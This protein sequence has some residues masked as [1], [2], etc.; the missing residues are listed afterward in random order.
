MPLRELRELL[1]D[2]GTAAQRGKT[3]VRVGRRAAK[4]FER[5]TPEERWALGKRALGEAAMHVAD[6]LAGPDVQVRSKP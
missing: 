1:F 5:L 6:S 3:F 2:L 4:N